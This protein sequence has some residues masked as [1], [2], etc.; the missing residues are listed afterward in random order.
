MPIERLR[1]KLAI[2]FPTINSQESPQFSSVQVACHL[3]LKSSQWGLQLCFRPHFNWRFVHKIMNVQSHKS[4]NFENFETKWH[5]GV[6]SVARHRKYYKEEGGGFPHVRAMVSL[7]SSCLPVAHPCTKMLQ[8]H[9]N[10][11]LFNLGKSMWVIELLI[12]LPSPHPGA[13]ACPFTFKMLQV[14]EHAPQFLLLLL[15]SFLDSQ[16]NPSKSLGVRHMKSNM[17]QRLLFFPSNKHKK[18]EMQKHKDS[19]N[20]SVKC[21]YCN[22]APKS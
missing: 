5:L 12:N 14:R 9:I 11:L 8:L 13:I 19:D 1:V 17:A 10:N 15:F 6:G 20:I 16:L 3:P 18:C 4:P 22:Y 2:W 21:K 7:V